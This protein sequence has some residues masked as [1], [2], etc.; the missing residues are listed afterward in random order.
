MKK[1]SNVKEK[2]S[3][4]EFL[5]ATATLG[6]ATVVPRSVFGKGYIP[7]TPSDN[8]FYIAPNGSDDA[9]GTAEK[10]FRTLNKALE[11][12]RKESGKRSIILKA[13]RYDNVSVELDSRD[14]GLEIRADGQAVLCG[15]EKLSGWR[16]CGDGTFCANLPSGRTGDLRM[17]AADGK[18]CDKSRYPHEGYLATASKFNSNWLSSSQGGWDIKPTEE[19]RTTLEYKPG[20]IPDDFDWQNAE[21][22]V[23]HRWDE[24]LVGMQALEKDKRLFRFNSPL[25]HPAGAFGVDSYLIWNSKLGMKPGSWRIDKSQGRLYYMP[26]EGQRVEDTEFHVPLHNSIITI[27]GDISDLTIDGVGF[28]VTD[29]PLGSGGFGA[30]RVTAAINSTANLTNC[31][32]KSLSFS[33]LSGWGIK[34]SGVNSRVIVE[35]CNVKNVGAGGISM[36]GNRRG[37]D[38]V[39]N[40]KNS[41]RANTVTRPGRIFFSAVGISASNCDVLDNELSELP[42][43]GITGGSLVQGNKIDRAMMILRDGAGIYISGGRG[44]R[45]VGNTVSNVTQE[46]GLDM[47]RHG[48]YLDEK[49]EDW[50]VEKNLTVD[51][52]S[53][54]LNHMAKNNVWRNNVFV[55]RYGE[56]QLLAIRCEGHTFECNAVHAAKEIVFI[57]NDGAITTLKNNLLHSGIGKIE[58]VPID[59][60]YVRSAPVTMDA[61]R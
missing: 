11:A 20:D 28:I 22:M 10:P 59:E 8:I 18:M 19:Q 56:I 38:I 2:L 23:F 58:R 4:R 35:G 13:G 44:G 60:Q 57:T 6:M 33:A 42:Y 37:D 25:T 31:L 17:L 51:C 24:S 29:A 53:A 49:C 5:T 54:M 12:T 9:A 1:I 26:L 61:Q 32:L 30:G 14:S 40:A 52:H 43:S 48:L 7:S 15:G 47:Q 27:T 39:E 50:V 46:P 45:M 21:V 16:N 55:N 34:L 3:R 41:I 36:R